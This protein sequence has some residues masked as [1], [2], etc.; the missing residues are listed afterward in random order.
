[1]TGVGRSEPIELGYIHHACRIFR[2]HVYVPRAHSKL[3]SETWAIRRPQPYHAHLMTRRSI[4]AA[5][6]AFACIPR[7]ARAGS[8]LPSEV[9]GIRL[10]RS[11]LALGAE[12]FARQEC[13]PFLFNHCMRTFFFGAVAMERHGNAYSADDAFVAASLHDLGL[14]KEFASAEGSFEVD[15]ADRAAQF[16]RASGAPASAA[17]DVWHAIALHDARF[18]LVEH[19]GG[20]AMLVAMGAGSDVLGPNADM[21]DP[22]RTAEIVTAFPRLKF[23]K[24][25]TALL[26]DHCRRKPLSQRSTWLEGLCREKSPSAWSAKL[27]DEIAAAPF[28]E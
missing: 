18:A 13:P 7:L 25:F 6:I 12:H 9:A 15:G 21:I 8:G 4:L 14:L 20:A 24:Q 2:K 23:K 11:A 16:A 19:R 28:T 22:K 27:E 3:R 17:D 26:V 10:P 5:V 1:M